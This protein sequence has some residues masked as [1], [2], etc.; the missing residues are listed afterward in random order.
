MKQEHSLKK[1]FVFFTVGNIVYTLSQYLLLILFT[2]NFIKEDVGG[3]LYAMAFVTP[4]VQPLEM[5]L[6]GLY[7]TDS[8]NRLN[9]GDYHSLRII[10]NL[11]SLLLLIFG[12]LLFKPE[13]FNIILVIGII[14]IIESQMDISY[15]SFQK[16]DYMYYISYSKIIRGM[17]T[18]IMVCLLILS[19]INLITI[20][21]SWLVLWG[22]IFV[23]IDLK[24]TRKIDS[25][26]FNLK[27]YFNYSNLI[28]LLKISWPLLLLDFVDKYYVNYPNLFIEQ[29]YGIKIVAIFGSILY[30]RSVSSQLIAPISNVTAPRLAVYWVE[31]NFIKFKSLLMKM[32]GIALLIGVCGILCGF[33]LG[34]W[35]LTLLFTKEYASYSEILIYVMIISA[36]CDGYLFF[37]TALTCMRKHWIKLPIHVFGFVMLIGISNIYHFKME[38]FMRILIIIELAIGLMYLFSVI[39]FFNKT[40]LKIN[41]E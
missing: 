19:S 20:L 22:L 8:G 6:R 9:L 32:I 11:M 31:N 18:L 4:L 2:K 30:F 40:K 33:F 10:C 27:K 35:V 7:V 12:G 36:I 29:N 34:E 38:V 41:F 26:F 39:Y 15:A 5:Q 3:Y 13:M 24:W 25:N 28:Y 23:F 17:S 37:G 21:Y 1:N 14:K 16:K